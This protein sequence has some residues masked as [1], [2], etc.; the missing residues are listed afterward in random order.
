MNEDVFNSQSRY[1]RLQPLPEVVSDTTA[2]AIDETLVR[3]SFSKWT[4]RVD[5]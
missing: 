1:S 2:L 5:R 4:E 3:D